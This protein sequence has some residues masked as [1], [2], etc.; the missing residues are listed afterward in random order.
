M[1]GVQEVFGLTMKLSMQVFLG[2]PRQ[3]EHARIAKR[4]ETFFLD[5]L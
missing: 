1:R 5:G 3:G 4:Y 2:R